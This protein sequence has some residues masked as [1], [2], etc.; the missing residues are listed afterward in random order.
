[1]DFFL[2]NNHVLMNYPSKAFILKMEK[3]KKSASPD[4][5]V[6]CLCSNISTAYKKFS[7]G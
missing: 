7:T 4:C 5:P 6:T 3:R 1:M 2:E